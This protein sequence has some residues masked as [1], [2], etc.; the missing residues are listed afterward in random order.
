MALPKQTECSMLID[1]QAGMQQILYEKG[2]AYFSACTLRT[3]QAGT[4][5]NAKN[6]MAAEET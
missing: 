3:Q 4:D 1:M 2:K 6:H 5:T